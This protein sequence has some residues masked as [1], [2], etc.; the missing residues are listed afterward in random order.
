MSGRDQ[1]R[2]GEVRAKVRRERALAELAER[3]HGVV[4][5]GQLQALG[6]S[7]RAIDQRLDCRQLQLAHREVYAVGHMR[8]SSHGRWMAAVLAYG[9]ESLLSHRS[10]A[11]LW[12][13]ARKSSGPIDVSAPSGRQGI[14][15]RTGVFIHRGKLDPDD[16]AEHGG[17]AVTTV[18]RTLFDFAESVGFRQ[19]ESAWEEADRLSLLELSAVERVCE[20]GYGRR[21]LK[22]VRR[23][24]AQAL[25]PAESTRSPL[26]HEFARFCREHELPPP[27]F[28]TIV[29]G[30][31]VDALWSAQRLV[32]ELDGFAYH[33]H[34]AAF[35]RD[36]TRDSALQVA[37][38]RILR[39]THRRLHRDPTT[40]ATQIRAMLGV[41][42]LIHP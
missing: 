3:Q 24:L 10:A 33:H 7:R 37:G 16:R 27:T 13:L 29:I 8:L 19:L 11:A 9:D 18:A 34:R 25:A 28:N 20:R 14:D 21:A 17:I 35:E 42:E 38:Y 31:E 32:V 6:F 23:L 26:E 39:I 15:R 1:A 40:I 41:S 36:R 4:A 2:Q 12:G 22:P 30:F 5:L